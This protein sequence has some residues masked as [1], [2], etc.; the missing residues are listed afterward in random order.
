MSVDEKRQ[1]ILALRQQVEDRRVALST[2]TNEA[3]DQVRETQMD[4]EIE[5]LEAELA[6]LGEIPEP[7]GEV[8]EPSVVVRPD[9]NLTGEVHKPELVEMADSLGI[10]GAHSMKK[11]ELIDAIRETTGVTDEGED[12]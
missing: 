8:S 3:N 4:R 9:V 2:A 6:A 12:S 5:R 11:D 10:E 7:T 1:R